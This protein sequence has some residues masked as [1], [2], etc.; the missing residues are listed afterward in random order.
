MVRRKNKILVGGIGLKDRGGREINKV[1][2]ERTEHFMVKKIKEDK[3]E[4]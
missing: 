3:S 4:D 2:W 1:M